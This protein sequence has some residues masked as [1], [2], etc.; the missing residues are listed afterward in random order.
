MISA[1]GATPAT[2]RPLSSTVSVQVLGVAGGGVRPEV[3]LEVRVR[4]VDAGVD[5][6]D[7]LAASSGPLPGVEHPY[8][9]LGQ[10]RI[11]KPPEAAEEGVVRGFRFQR[12]VAVVRLGI[13]DSG[14]PAEVR[15]DSR[16]R[17]LD[18]DHLGPRQAEGVLEADVGLATGGAALQS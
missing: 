8:A 1:S 3:R 4:E 10:G 6:G 14:L 11:R 5:H 15:D 17:A 9:R 12:L 7:H 18:L 13:G 2:P 16:D